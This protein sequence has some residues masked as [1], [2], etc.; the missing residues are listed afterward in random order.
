MFWTN[1]WRWSWAFV[2]RYYRVDS[3]LSW[4]CWLYLHPL[5]DINFIAMWYG[6]SSETLP[7]MTYVHKRHI[8]HYI[9]SSCFEFMLSSK[10]R[11]YICN[12]FDVELLPVTRWC[13]QGV[14]L[15]NGIITAFWIKLP[16]YYGTAIWRQLLLY[17]CSL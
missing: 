17:H 15:G 7:T 13:S 4:L 2:N 11:W 6:E 14:T 16:L 1:G 3:I 9:C 5:H 8:V 10:R 12:S